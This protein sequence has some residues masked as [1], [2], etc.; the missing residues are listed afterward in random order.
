M[1]NIPDNLAYTKD[2][3]WFLDLG[4]GRARVGITDHAQHE[5]GDIVFVEMPSPG[6]TV[7]AG[8]AVA[9]VES[10]KSVSD[11]YSP[12]SGEITARNEGLDP[13]TINSDPYGAGWLFELRVTDRGKLLTAA[14]YQAQIGK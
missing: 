13:A 9:V 12:V 1:S 11:V 5:L 4:D 8:D 6:K 10:V 14:E 2:H 3:E 7:Q